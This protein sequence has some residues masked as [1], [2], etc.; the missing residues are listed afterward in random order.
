M[1]TL[2]LIAITGI[3]SWMAFNNRKLAD[4]WC[5]GRPPWT[6]TSSTTA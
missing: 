1:I 6:S 3:V 2:I 5:C 4:R